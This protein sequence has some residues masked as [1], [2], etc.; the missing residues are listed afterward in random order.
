MLGC[1]Y[2][3]LHIAARCSYIHTCQ[4]LLEAS[5]GE[6]GR[7][8]DGHGQTALHA[9]VEGMALGDMVSEGGVLVCMEYLIQAGLQPD[10]TDYEMRTCVNHNKYLVIYKC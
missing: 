2:A 1:T 6:L 8:V 4:F 9:A 5:G 10:Q 7:K 3:G